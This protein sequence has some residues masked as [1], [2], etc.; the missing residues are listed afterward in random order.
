MLFKKKSKSSSCESRNLSAFH[1]FWSFISHCR[2]YSSSLPTGLHTDGDCL[3][4]FWLHPLVAHQQLLNKA[5]ATQP[6]CAQD[7]DLGTMGTIEMTNRRQ[8]DVENL[9][10]RRPR[11]RHLSLCESLS[12]ACVYVI[13]GAD[14]S[15][16]CMCLQMTK[17]H[18]KFWCEAT[19]IF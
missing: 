5:G 4:L 7:I 3:S 2:C 9:A 10:P 13:W 18:R 11:E 14:S 15:L 6:S 17:K 12:Q 16:P 8:R 19:S 1:L